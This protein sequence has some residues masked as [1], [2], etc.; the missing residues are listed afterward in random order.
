[1][2]LAAAHCHLMTAAARDPGFTTMT[3][4]NRSKKPEA[5]KAV[6]LQGTGGA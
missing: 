6:I 5:N 2:N 4:V 3:R 1:V